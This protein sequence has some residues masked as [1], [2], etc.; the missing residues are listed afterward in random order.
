MGNFMV[1]KNTRN[2]RKQSSARKLEGREIAFF[3]G[4]R[5][6]EARKLKGSEFLR[7]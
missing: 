2:A 6:L 7:E 3:G 4:A 1:R 5:K